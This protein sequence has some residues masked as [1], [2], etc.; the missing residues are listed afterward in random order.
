MNGSRT[1]I[2][3]LRHSWLSSAEAPLFDLVKVVRE[4]SPLTAY[5]VTDIPSTVLTEERIFSEQHNI[6]LKFS[7]FSRYSMLLKIEESLHKRMLV[8]IRDKRSFERSSLERRKDP[9]A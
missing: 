2:T 6:R 9:V 1:D 7:T 8:I 3:F 4:P 5:Q